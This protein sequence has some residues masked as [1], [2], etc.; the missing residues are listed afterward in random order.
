MRS[1]PST[2]ILLATLGLIGCQ[3]SNPTAPPEITPSLLEPSSKASSVEIS[4]AF[5][6]DGVG[7]CNDWG[8]VPS[9]HYQERNC[10]THYTVTGGILAEGWLIEKASFDFTTGRGTA[11]GPIDLT[12]TEFL[13][14]PVDGTMDGQ[15]TFNCNGWYCTTNFV[16]QGGGELD[17]VKLR[18]QAEGWFSFPTSFAYTATIVDPHGG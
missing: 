8:T 7:T 9:G 5:H 16:L 6:L 4:G 13:G 11:S 12:V 1:R 2:V 15:I 17:G 3:D 10:E 14:N 18:A